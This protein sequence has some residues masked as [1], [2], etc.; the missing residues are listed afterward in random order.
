M[1]D[2]GFSD[3]EEVMDMPGATMSGFCRPSSVGPMEENEATVFSFSTDWHGVEENEA[4]AFRLAPT[5]MTFLA[6]DGLLI[7]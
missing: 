3:C 5:E 1:V 2:P 6:P 4:A 7:V